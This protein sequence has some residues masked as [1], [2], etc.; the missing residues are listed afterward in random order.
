MKA[1]PFVPQGADQQGRHKPTIE[2]DPANAV[3]GMYE[4][5]N[6]QMRSA[7]LMV[8]LFM[9]KFLGAIAFCLLAAWLWASG[10]LEQFGGWK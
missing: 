7:D 3:M 6:E 4:D 8:A 1:R 10:I 2:P 5:A 9:M